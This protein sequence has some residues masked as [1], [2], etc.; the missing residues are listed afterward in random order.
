MPSLVLTIMLFALILLSLTQFDILYA[1]TSIITV[2]FRP[3]IYVT[4]YRRTTTLGA[5]LFASSISIIRF[6]SGLSYI[7]ISIYRQLTKIIAILDFTGYRS[8]ASK[9]AIP[10]AISTSSQISSFMGFSPNNTTFSIPSLLVFNRL[11]VTSFEGIGSRFDSNRFIIILI[12][13]IFLVI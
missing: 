9:T 10:T 3:I 8:Q 12:L 6:F 13:L 1:S 5:G 2:I 4:E 11:I 7:Y